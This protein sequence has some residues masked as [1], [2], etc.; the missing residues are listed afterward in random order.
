MDLLRRLSLRNADVEI[1]KRTITEKRPKTGLGLSKNNNKEDIFG[2]LH[3]GTEKTIDINESLKEQ[4][5]DDFV[6]IEL[7][8]EEEQ[9]L[10]DI[11]TNSYE[12]IDSKSSKQILV[13]LAKKRRLFVTCRSRAVTHSPLIEKHSTGRTVLYL[14]P[15]YRL[16]VSP[17]ELWYIKHR[18]AIFIRP[19][20]RKSNHKPIHYTEKVEFEDAIG[21]GI[22]SKKQDLSGYQLVF[23]N[24]KTKEVSKLSVSGDF[25]KSCEERHPGAHDVRAESGPLKRS[26]SIEFLNEDG[27]AGDSL[28]AENVARKIEQG[29]VKEI[30]CDSIDVSSQFSHRSTDSIC[31]NSSLKRSYS[32]EFLNE[33]DDGDRPFSSEVVHYKI[34]K[35]EGVLVYSEIE[36]PTNDTEMS[37]SRSMELQ[38]KTNLKRSY[39]IE[40]LDE[41]NDSKSAFTYETIS[42]KIEKG[43][44]RL[45]YDDSGIRDDIDIHPGKKTKRKADRLKTLGIQMDINDD[46]DLVPLSR[47]SKAYSVEILCEIEDRAVPIITDELECQPVFD[48]EIIATEV[49]AVE[50]EV[51]I[52]ADN[53]NFFD[54]ESENDPNVE[55]RS[56]NVEFLDER[57]NLDL[58][59]GLNKTSTPSKMPLHSPKKSPLQTVHVGLEFEKRNKSENGEEELLGNEEDEYLMY[60]DFLKRKEGNMSLNGHHRT[61]SLKLKTIIVNMDTHHKRKRSSL[62]HDKRYQLEFQAERERRISMLKQA[63][64]ARPT[65]SSSSLRTVSVETDKEEVIHDVDELKPPELLKKKAYSVEYLNEYEGDRSVFY[66]EF[67]DDEEEP[68]WVLEC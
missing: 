39:S 68:K 50:A 40:F 16:T 17:T 43:E 31:E 35:G 5:E 59:L 62:Q 51:D 12:D 2:F 21:T 13:Y 61:P 23:S 26:Y 55:K 47:Q 9:E 8:D 67:I 19:A 22:P 42:N 41:T 66:E 4:D 65:S 32:V 27:V 29:E 10:A 25:T 36:A 45:I 56:F 28:S 57:P 38:E 1:V 46:G 48:D 11:D 53:V 24:E 14:R 52:F 7:I 33:T 44:G 58:D 63:R 54:S 34:E 6:V 20:I 37:D 30:F 49:N 18:S 64:K 15:Y 3:N 60:D